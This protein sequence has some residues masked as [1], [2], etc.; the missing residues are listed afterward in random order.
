[1]LFEG[2]VYSFSGWNYAY[3]LVNL[4]TAEVCVGEGAVCIA[5]GCLPRFIVQYFLDNK[6][7]G[8]G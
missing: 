5:L 8:Q 4:Q 6:A 2:V 7:S 3:T 1:M